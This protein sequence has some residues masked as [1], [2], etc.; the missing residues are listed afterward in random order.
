MLSQL[1]IL[2]LNGEDLMEVGAEVVAGDQ[3]DIIP[4][5]VIIEEQEQVRL[6]I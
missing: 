2:Q 4:E 5:A 6:V 3:N 1:K